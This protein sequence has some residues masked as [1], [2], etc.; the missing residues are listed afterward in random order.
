[1]VTP[2]TSSRLEVACSGRHSFASPNG[3]LSKTPHPFLVI[4]SGDQ[5]RMIKRICVFCGSSRGRRPEY[6]VAARE[7]GNALVRRKIG[8]VYGGGKVGLMGEVARQVFEQGGE[9]IGVVPVGLSQKEIA[10][11]D[12][13]DLRIVQTMHERKAMMADLADGFIALPGGFGTLDEFFEIVTWAQ[14]GLHHKPLGLLDVA[15]YYH[16]MGEFMDHAVEEKFIVAG[17]RS[18]ILLEEDPDRMHDRMEEYR[19]PLIDKAAWVLGIND[20]SDLT[21]QE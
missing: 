13:P 10:Y 19:S 12:L 11:T 21:E 17:H 15:S 7:L 20:S 1:M 4:I 3:L 8:L 16:K 2:G 14:L 18:M 5:K 9:V 6:G